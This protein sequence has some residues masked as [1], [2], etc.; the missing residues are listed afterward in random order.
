[1]KRFA[2]VVVL[3]VSGCRD[4]Q[5]PPIPGTG[6]PGAVT[7]RVVWQ[8]P[9]RLAPQ[10]AQGASIFI[11][12][13]NLGTTASA[14][15][16][17]VIEGITSSE[18]ALLIRFDSDRDG[19]AERQRVISLAEL[20]AGRGRTVSAGELSLNQSAS[21]TGTI[22]FVDAMPAADVSGSTAFVPGLPLAT[23]TDTAGDFVL[24]GVSEGPTQLAAV[25]TGYEPWLSSSLALRGGEELRLSRIVLE[26]PTV[27]PS[28]VVRARVV[29]LDGAAL[30]GVDVRLGNAT[31]TT[32]ATG[33]WRFAGVATGRYDLRITAPGRQPLALYNLLVAGPD[34]LALPDLVMG[35]GSGGGP[36]LA[37]EVDREQD[38]G[39]NPMLDGGADAGDDAGTPTD[40]GFNIVIVAP[41]PLVV[42]L[43]ASVMLEV[44]AQPP[45]LPRAQI[46]WTASP[47]NAVFFD[48][49]LSSTPNITGIAPGQ[50][51][52]DVTVVHDGV[53]QNRRVSGTVVLG[54][55][56][57]AVTDAGATAVYAFLESGEPFLSSMPMTVTVDG[58][59]VT[60]ETRANLLNRRVVA[61][62][63]TPTTPGQTLTLQTTVV[64]TDG[65]LA[66]L[67]PASLQTGAF[68]F[69][70]SQL[71]F[72]AGTVIPQLGANFTPTGLMVFATINGGPCAM[73][74]LVT[75]QPAT[76]VTTQGLVSGGSYDGKKLI[77][78]GTDVQGWS[79]SSSYVKG[80]GG[81]NAQPTPPGQTWADQA[82][83]RSVGVD[84]GMIELFTWNT[85]GS[86][87]NPIAVAPVSSPLLV[88]A[89]ASTQV[90]GISDTAVLAIS[91]AGNAEVHLIPGNTGLTEATV[92][93]PPL[94]NLTW[95][96][97]VNTYEGQAVV[98]ARTPAQSSIFTIVNNTWNAELS[99]GTLQPVDVVTINRRAYVLSIDFSS[100]DLVLTKVDVA[101]NATSTLTLP[102]NSN[103]RAAELAV[104]DFGDFAVVWAEEVGAG[105]FTVRYTQL[106]P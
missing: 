29:D 53:M 33:A 85:A 10:P 27:A 49:P 68:S 62:F 72:D 24:E 75:F 42:Q 96:R 71:A 74:C 93:R 100:N 60:V 40:A 64:L 78:Y 32:D 77:A 30:A 43:D 55:T 50:F 73:D 94:S 105:R 5:L 86:W 56:A 66:T 44:R 14:D 13:S 8:R 11:L 26:R 23:L 7:G 2:V 61:L 15:G 51:A 82:T 16:R 95:G 31:T 103:V 90:P 48:D 54:P 59:P 91:T 83:L 70:P 57:I 3:V 41:M 17:F 89:H 25:R 19:T 104:S 79:G 67:G 46:Q 80:A 34:E 63:D 99:L 65:G 38:A 22:T 69:A 4:L 102:F 58:S 97:I 47:P 37:T 35:P 1:M 36:S 84:A 28:G 20:G 18:G 12:N 101:G 52:L 9:G 76:G 87:I 39:F 6:S 88:T 106:V 98:F 81:W 45:I 21:V 92:S